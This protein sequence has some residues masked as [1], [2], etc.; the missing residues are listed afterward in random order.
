MKIYTVCC[1]LMHHVMDLFHMFFLIQVICERHVVFHM[2]RC[3]MF[4]EKTEKAA[5]L[6]LSCSLFEPSFL[7][8]CLENFCIPSCNCHKS[9]QQDN[10]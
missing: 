6:R 2:A 3:V 1:C 9:Q 8:K 7:L 4:H 10:W 5:G